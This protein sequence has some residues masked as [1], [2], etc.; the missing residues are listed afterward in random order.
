[1]YNP[2]LAKQAVAKKTGKSTWVKISFTE[3]KSKENSHITKQQHQITL[4]KHTN[5]IVRQHEY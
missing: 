2:R 1:M 5:V 4:K 3:N